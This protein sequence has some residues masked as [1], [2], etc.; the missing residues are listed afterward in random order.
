[1]I[2]ALTAVHGASGT[3]GI[4]YPRCL[5]EGGMAEASRGGSDELFDFIMYCRNPKREC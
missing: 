5:P 2:I 3:G 4:A 1:L